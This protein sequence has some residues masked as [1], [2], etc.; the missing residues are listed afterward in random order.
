[1]SIFDDSEQEEISKIKLG[2]IPCKF[3]YYKKNQIVN[4]STHPLGFFLLKLFY[5][6]SD[7]VLLI[8]SEKLVITFN[9][10][11]QNSKNI[12]PKLK[13]CVFHAYRLTLTGY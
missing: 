6:S 3:I 8:P 9:N 4:M 2:I 1:M 13:V 10:E 5:S 11:K 7:H 12:W